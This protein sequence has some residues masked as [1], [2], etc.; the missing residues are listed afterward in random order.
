MISDARGVKS[1]PFESFGTNI[2]V[3]QPP[4][5]S[6]KDTITTVVELPNFNGSIKA[7]LVSETGEAH[8]GLLVVNSFEES[9][10]NVNWSPLYDFGEETYGDTHQV[11]LINITK[12]YIRFNGSVE[13]AL[14]KYIYFYNY[15]IY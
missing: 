3:I 7:L 1:V 10:D 5:T 9:D 12:P 11:V 2:L 14:G 15:L 4:G 6:N 8:L 13:G